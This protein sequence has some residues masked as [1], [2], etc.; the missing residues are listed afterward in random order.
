MHDSGNKP[1]VLTSK[2]QR[3]EIIIALLNREICQQLSLE[4]LATVV[5]LSSSR[6]R[7][8]FKDKTGL[9]PAAYL[10]VLRLKKAKELLETT[11]LNLKEIMNRIGVQD[12]SHFARDFKNAYGLSPSEYRKVCGQAGRSDG[13]AVAK[14]ALK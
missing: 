10:R 11:F 7:H 13:Q 2:D 14:S 4:E 9:T 3:I 6:L 12:R 1:V 5:N 8:L